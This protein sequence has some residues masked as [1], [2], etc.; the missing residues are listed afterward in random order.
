MPGPPFPGEQ[1]DLY[2]GTT[3]YWNLVPPDQSTKYPPTIQFE[4]KN[5]TKVTINRLTGVIIP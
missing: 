5:G 1:V 4:A 2:D 3:V